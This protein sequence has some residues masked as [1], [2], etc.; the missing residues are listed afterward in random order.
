VF[1][2]RTVINRSEL[3]RL[4]P[5]TRGLFAMVDDADYEM[6][7][8]FKWRAERG[9]KGTNTFYAIT[10]QNKNGRKA[11]YMHR[12]LVNVPR[13]MFVDHKNTNP[14]DNQRDNLRPATR[15]QNSFNL[16]KTRP[17]KSGYK[18]VFLRPIKS[19]ISAAKPWYVRLRC[20]VGFKIHGG[21]FATAEEAA[22][23]YDELAH[24]H[25]GE[26]ARPNFPRENP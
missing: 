17:S 25:F 11:I 12:L 23:R 5:L 4:I 22:R 9:W 8:R 10:G 16:N 7:S 24:I 6:L 20:K 14:L 1:S 19:P 21:Y 18:G 2:T 3:M 15:L 26:F 13:G